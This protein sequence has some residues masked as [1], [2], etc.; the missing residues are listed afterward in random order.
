MEQESETNLPAMLSP[1]IQNATRLLSGFSIL[2]IC[3]VGWWS[4]DAPD[5]LGP[6]GPIAPPQSLKI[7]LNDAGERDLMLMPGIGTTTAR[8]IIDDRNQNGPFGSLDELSR[9]PGIGPKT[10]EAI[11]PYCQPISLADQDEDE[12][13]LAKW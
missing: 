11:S 10:I 12:K 6:S 2:G 7:E 5:T 9:V 3:L 1:S 8:R 4:T 13:V